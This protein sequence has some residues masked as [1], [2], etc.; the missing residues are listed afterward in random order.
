MTLFVHADTT[1]EP[2]T[3][4]PSARV[5]GA[6]SATSATGAI[7]LSVVAL[8]ALT[9]CGASLAQPFD[10]M[11]AGQVTVHRLQNYE[12]PPQQTQPGMPGLPIPLPPQLQQLP[13]LAAGL[14]PGLLP[15]GMMPGTQPPP[16]DANVQRFH[17]FRILATQVA[18]AKQR[19]EVLDIFGKDQGFVVPKDN[20]MFAEF[21]LKLEAQAGSPPAEMLVSL[22]CSQVQAFNFNWPYGQKTGLTS[23]AARRIVAVVNG[24]FTH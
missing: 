8:A 7:A 14:L 11:K 9:G 19:D 15:P 3:E 2:R 16:P 4:G 1:P 18:D 22:S 24:V 20:C 5:V 21:G 13:Q 6:T 23:D 10:Q 17:N 12:P